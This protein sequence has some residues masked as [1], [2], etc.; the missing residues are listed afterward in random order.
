MTSQ[1]IAYEVHVDKG[2]IVE[3]PLTKDELA[4]EAAEQAIWAQQEAEAA[5]AAETAAAKKA[6]I[7]AA[8]ADATGYTPDELREALNA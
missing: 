4:K 1:Q 6:A 5:A 2:E 3:R 7:L 8:L